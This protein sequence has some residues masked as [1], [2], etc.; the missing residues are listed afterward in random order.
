M[1]QMRRLLKAA[2]LAT[3]VLVSFGAGA[4]TASILHLA[5]PIVTVQLKNVSDQKI[6]AVQLEHEHGSLTAATIGPGD[7]RLVRFYSP[8]E[9]SYSIKVVFADGRTLSGGGGYVEAGYKITEVISDDKIKT[10]YGITE[11]SDGSIKSD[12]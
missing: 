11:V 3:L 5:S 9:S 7:S 10:N 1:T 2:A 8:A 4:I 6:K 12:P